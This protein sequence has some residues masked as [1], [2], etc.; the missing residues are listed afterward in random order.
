MDRDVFN[1]TVA[2]LT[3]MLLGKDSKAKPGDFNRDGLVNGA[4]YSKWLADNGKTVPIYSG[5]D[6]NGDAR[7]TSADLAIWLANVPEPSSL[8]L[9]LIGMY[10]A[11]GRKRCR[12]FL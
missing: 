4:D 7:V 11:V 9:V 3:A 12:G 2:Q 8:A 6:G 1:G 10:A 5:A